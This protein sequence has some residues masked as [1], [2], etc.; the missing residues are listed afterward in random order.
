MLAYL[1][2]DIMLLKDKNIT[3]DILNA[4]PVKLRNNLDIVKKN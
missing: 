2:Y 3:Q 4:L 1:L